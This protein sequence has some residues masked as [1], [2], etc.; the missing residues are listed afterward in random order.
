MRILVAEDDDL[1]R[2]LLKGVLR[3]AGHEPLL[4]PNGR[5]AWERL[6]SEGADLAILDVNMPEMDGLELTRRIRSHETWKGLPI[7]MLT[8]R[9]LVEDELRGME[10]GADDYLAKPFKPPMLL[11]RLDALKRRTQAAS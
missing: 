10:T 8:I 7:L 4:C 3:D 1:T 2:E 11:A 5:A 6:L 9:T